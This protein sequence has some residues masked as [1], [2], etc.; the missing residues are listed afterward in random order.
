[1]NS[2]FRT[3]PRS[4]SFCARNVVADARCNLGKPERGCNAAIA[5]PRGAPRTWPRTLPGDNPTT[6]R[7]RSK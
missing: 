6:I 7:A 3:P 4:T 1:M 5:R 2:A